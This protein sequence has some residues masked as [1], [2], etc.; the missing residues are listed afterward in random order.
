V[1]RN[2]EQAISFLLQPYKKTEFKWIVL[3]RTV[4][5]PR[6]TEMGLKR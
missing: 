6:P 3:T 1:K 5:K 2:G 4:Q